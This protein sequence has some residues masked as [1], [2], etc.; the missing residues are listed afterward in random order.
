[1]GPPKP[2][3]ILLNQ[4]PY[5]TAFRQGLW[6]LPGARLSIRLSWQLLLGA[7]TLRPENTG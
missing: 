3:S 4:G 2:Y 7:G 5:S 1:M 6:A